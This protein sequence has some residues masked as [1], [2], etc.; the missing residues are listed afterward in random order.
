M[1]DEKDVINDSVKEAI[2]DRFKNPILGSFAIAWCLINWKL[3]AILLKS[4]TPILD[5]IL[6]IEKSHMDNWKMYILPAIVAFMVTL[7][8][9]W[10]SL[11]VVYIKIL[12][13]SMIDR[14]NIEHELRMAGLKLRLEAMNKE[15][16]DLNQ[17]RRDRVSRGFTP[18]PMEE[19]LAP[20]SSSSD[21]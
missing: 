20:V 7:L 3:I 14:K 2:S 9:P 17:Y 16:Y 21:K 10:L 5:T 6:I 19:I 18:T 13:Q 15:M 4:S 11:L 1:A 8:Y 12:P